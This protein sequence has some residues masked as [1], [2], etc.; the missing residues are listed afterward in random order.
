MNTVQTMMQAHPK[1]YAV[2]SERLAAAISAAGECTL[3]CTICADA[4]LA[5]DMVPELR[6]CIRLNLDCSDVCATTSCALA[7]ETE[8]DIGLLR[9]QVEACV[10]ACSACASECEQH[11]NM[12]EHCR[13]CAESCRRCEKACKDLLEVLTA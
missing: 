5:E 6:R 7:R 12:H 11:A 1:K 9:A 2:N 4:C 8:P 3:I 10:K 13:L